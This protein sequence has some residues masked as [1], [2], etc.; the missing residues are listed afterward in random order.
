[1]VDAGLKAMKDN[2][3]VG[4]IGPVQLESELVG[5]IRRRDGFGEIGKQADIPDQGH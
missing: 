1:M 4:V 5:D 2:C 3:A